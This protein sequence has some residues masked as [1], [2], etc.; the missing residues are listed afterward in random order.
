[1]R[2]RQSQVDCQYCSQP[3]RDVVI[4]YPWS[5]FRSKRRRAAA[6]RVC[7]ILRPGLAVSPHA[8]LL[9]SRLSSV[10]HSCISYDSNGSSLRFVQNR[11]V[12]NM[13]LPLI[14]KLLGQIH[15]FMREKLLH[16][17][18]SNTPPICPPSRISFQRSVMSKE[19]QVTLTQAHDYSL[20]R[21]K[22]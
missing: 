10:L 12:R 20:P 14:T 4:I 15:D 18:L 9:T 1:M 21:A 19:G 3:K 5:T 22:S 11:G 8:F 16:L 13:P 17:E 2:R 6:I 7:T